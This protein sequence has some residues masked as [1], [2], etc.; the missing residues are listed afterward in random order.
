[1]QR[2]LR[3]RERGG[4]DAEA[5]PQPR[6]ARAVEAELPPRPVLAAVRSREELARAS[7]YAS[8]GREGKC[9]T[10]VRTP[11]L[12]SKNPTTVAVTEAGL[13]LQMDIRSRGVCGN[14]S[15]ADHRPRETVTLRFAPCLKNSFHTFLLVPCTSWLETAVSPEPNPGAPSRQSK[16]HPTRS[17]VPA[18]HTASP[19]RSVPWSTACSGAS[20]F[21]TRR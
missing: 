14:S 4:A 8:G 16:H 19:T 13:F 3:G 12:L 2:A 5:L 18:A 10:A 21:S 6:R 7:R 11:L 17:W 9:S 20:C 1:M 15:T